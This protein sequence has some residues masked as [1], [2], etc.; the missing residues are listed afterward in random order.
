MLV[1][2]S[3][4]LLLREK[5]DIFSV[6]Y[7]KFSEKQLKKLYAVFTFIT[8]DG[9]FQ[10]LP[11]C[12][13]TKVI[14]TF[15]T[16][17]RRSIQRFSP[18]AIK[19][20]AGNGSSIL[21]KIVEAR[22]SRFL[23]KCSAMITNYFLYQQGTQFGAQ[24]FSQLGFGRFPS[25]IFGQM[26]LSQSILHLDKFGNVYSGDKLWF[27]GVALISFGFFLFSKFPTDTKKR[28]SILKK[29]F[30]QFYYPSDLVWFWKHSIY[31]F[32]WMIITRQKT[33]ESRKQVL[34]NVT[35]MFASFKVVLKS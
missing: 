26:A 27:S 18:F 31:S 9:C 28:L 23:L 20:N 11:G 10:I 22:F 1:M 5:R 12:S 32:L 8:V 6:Y 19:V 30:L 13:K 4:Y 25:H 33:Y 3:G 16:F 17:E 34:W 35:F 15:H 7:E 29:D 24:R 14:S 21:V 2:N